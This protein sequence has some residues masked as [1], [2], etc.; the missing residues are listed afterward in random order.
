[1]LAYLA[2]TEEGGET[3]F[4]NVPAPGGQ[5]DESFSEC[6]RYHLAAKPKKGTAIL[7]HSMKPNGELEKKSL[8]TAC[9]VIKGVKWSAA[10]WLH[11]DHYAMGDEL[12]AARTLGSTA[13]ATTKSRAAINR[14]ED[15]DGL[16][17]PVTLP[18]APALSPGR[19]VCADED[20]L[21]ET[22][23][24]AGE[25]ERNPVYMVGSRA[26]PGRCVVSCGRCDLVLETGAERQARPFLARDA[27]RDAEVQPGGRQRFSSS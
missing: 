4:P 16:A 11:T 27:G 26:R 7:F 3:V 12:D 18:K 8:H 15:D 17:A 6:A 22:W 9:P 13:A 21:C 2:D 14:I 1:M 10:K 23:A 24:D 5:N 25:C 19:R 20:D